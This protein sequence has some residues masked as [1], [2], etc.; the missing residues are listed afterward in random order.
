MFMINLFIGV[1]FYNF[2]VASKR[3]KHK[4]LSD[5]QYYWLQLQKFIVFSEPDLELR[6]PR[7]GSLRYYVYSLIN[8]KVFDYFIYL[9]LIINILVLS[10]PYDGASVDYM[11]ALYYIHYCFNILLIMEAFL[12]IFLHGFD[13][14]IRNY[15]NRYDF[16]VVLTAIVD[17]FIQY[18]IGAFLKL[19]RLGD[20]IVKG[21][22]VVRIIRLLRLVR[23][24]K[25]VEKLIYILMI[26]LPMVLNIFLFCILIYYIYIIFGCNIFRKINKGI[27]F[28]DYVNF[29]N[30]SYAIMTLFKVSTAD[31]WGFIMF[32]AM[33]QINPLSALYF[34]SF[35]ILT[36]YV[37]TNLFILVLLQ[38][39]ESYSSNPN[40]PLHTFRDYLSRFRKVWATFI[41]FKQPTK[42]HQRNL[43]NFLTALKPPLGMP[44]LCLKIRIFFLFSKFL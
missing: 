43:V 19:I 2:S 21:L 30:C 18:Y 22:R 35:Y 1:I 36:S 8:S 39:F 33:D 4:F 9:S 25:G 24:N 31:N 17:I 16:F 7:S 13:K 32:D 3:T 40:N 20:Q 44:F 41:D 28:D 34:I 38:Q 6:I 42:I 11:R 5:S 10:M 27:V 14:Y 29:K 37:L 23:R 15:W 26:S 12:K